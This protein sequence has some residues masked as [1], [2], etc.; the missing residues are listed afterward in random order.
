VVKTET[1]RRQREGKQWFSRNWL[2][3]ALLLLLLLA[4][5]GVDGA[6]EDGGTVAIVGLAVVRIF[7]VLEYRNDGWIGGLVD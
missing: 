2:V 5:N 3:V 1:S 4:C 6:N 7:C